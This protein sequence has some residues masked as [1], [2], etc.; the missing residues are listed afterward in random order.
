MSSPSCSVDPGFDSCP[1]TG[2]IVWEATWCV[3]LLGGHSPNTL[4]RRGL[5]VAQNKLL[6]IPSVSWGDAV[7]TAT[8]LQVRLS[9]IRIPVRVR[10][11]SPIIQDSFQDPCSLLFNGYWGHEVGGWS[12]HS[13]ISSANAKNEQS[14]TS[15]SLHVFMAKTAATS[16]SVSYCFLLRPF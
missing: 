14:Y 16:T 15:T 7:S 5:V 10:H 4:L 2:G 11:L 9:G 13:N 1:K 12:Y 3:S 8:R 6:V